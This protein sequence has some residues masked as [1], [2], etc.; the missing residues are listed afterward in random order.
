MRRRTRRGMAGG[1]WLSR[2]PARH[3]AR[4]WGPSPRAKD[5]RGRS[6]RRVPLARHPCVCGPRGA[7]LG[8]GTDHD[9]S[10]AQAWRKR[11]KEPE[12]L[13]LP[14][15]RRPRRPLVLVAAV[16]GMALSLVVLLS[17]GLP[18]RTGLILDIGLVVCI[19]VMLVASRHR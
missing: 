4:R 7:R 12:R 16:A 3:T 5:V 13:L 1:P 17:P 11:R 19:L 6:G 10:Q 14:P 18:M 9:K 15:N 2:Y 8:C